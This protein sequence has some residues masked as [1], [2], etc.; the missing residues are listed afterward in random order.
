MKLDLY[1]VTKSFSL[2]YTQ[3]GFY[4]YEARYPISDMR[5]KF[6]NTPGVCKDRELCFR[7][8]VAIMVDR[9]T[10]PCLSDKITR[11]LIDVGLVELEW[12]LTFIYL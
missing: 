4:C 7:W 2:Y 8:P 11:V 9:S 5:K 6:Q 12:E 10:D 1:H 3:T